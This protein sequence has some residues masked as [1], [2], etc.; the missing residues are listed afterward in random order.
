VSF[1]LDFFDEYLLSQLTTEEICIKNSIEKIMERFTSVVTRQNT[2]PKTV[3][4]RI[5]K[6]HV[7]YIGNVTGQ[8]SIRV[9]TKL[10]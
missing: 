10:E 5:D 6:N 9:T 7:D 2:I 3:I 8:I 1:S 4:F